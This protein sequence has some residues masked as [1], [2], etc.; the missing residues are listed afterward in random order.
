MDIGGIPPPCKLELFS[1][2]YLNTC[3]DQVVTCPVLCKFVCN[4]SGATG[5]AATPSDSYL[6]L[7]MTYEMRW[8]L[9]VL[10][11]PIQAGPAAVSKRGG[12]ILV[13]TSYLTQIYTRQK[14][15][16]LSDT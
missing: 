1:S 9:E 11:N 5:D 7:Y 6:V 15:L 14:D 13:I 3:E 16:K 2:H 12:L 4:I 8:L 10:F